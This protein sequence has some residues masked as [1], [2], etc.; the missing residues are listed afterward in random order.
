[1]T[2][3]RAKSNKN[4]NVNPYNNFDDNGR[5]IHLD[6]EGSAIERPI[7]EYPYSFSEHC[8]WAVL[9]EKRKKIDAMVTRGGVYTDRLYLHDSDKYNMA[10]RHVWNN[11]GQFFDSR[12]P[13]DI[14]KM[15]QHYYDNN[16]IKLYKVVKSCNVST[17][18]PIWYLAFYTE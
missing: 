15:L 13:K 1:M 9:G 17:G 4:G 8:T 11:E 7:S 2:V 12:K 18:Y 16:K 5:F 10:C 3:K 14:E 6:Y